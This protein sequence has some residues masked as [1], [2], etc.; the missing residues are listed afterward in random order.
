MDKKVVSQK[1]VKN[2]FGFK[3]I[4]TVRVFGIVRVS[5]DR[6]ARKEMSLDEQK[7]FI[8]KF[9]QAKSCVHAPQTWK[10]VGMVIETRTPARLVKGKRSAELHNQIGLRKALELASS[11]LIDA[12]V[13]PKATYLARN[14]RELFDVYKEF[15]EN[16]VAV[17]LLD[18]NLDT[19]TPEGRMMLNIHASLD[20]WQSECMARR[21]KGD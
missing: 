4:K 11:G 21:R 19:S 9:V 18:L 8:Q 15:C 14:T 3:G 10:L 20:R 13:V 16:K 7:K 12:V 1:K 5:T 17:I 2:V 6:Q